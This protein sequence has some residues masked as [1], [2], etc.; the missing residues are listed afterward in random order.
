MLGVMIASS[1]TRESRRGRSSLTPRQAVQHVRRWLQLAELWLISQ[2]SAEEGSAVERMA[3]VWAGDL[4]HCHLCG[5][6]GVDGRGGCSNMSY[7]GKEEP[8]PCQAG[9]GQLSTA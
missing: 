7:S 5:T 4:S 6:R 3:A 1:G 9:E 8:C 2:L